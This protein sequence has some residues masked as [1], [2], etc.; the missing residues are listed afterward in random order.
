M[1]WA[2]A[3]FIVAAAGLSIFFF[4]SDL[5][6][7]PQGDLAQVHELDGQL[8]RVA[9]DRLVPLAVGDW[10][11]GKEE[12]RSGKNTHAVLRLD[13]DSLVELDERSS[14]RVRRGLRG[15]RVRVDRGRIIVE[16]SK[17]GSGH[18]RVHTD[19][20]Q[21]AV[22]GTIFGVSHGTKGSRVSVVEGEV[23]VRHAG[24]L[25]SLLGGQQLASR[26][27]LTGREIQ[28]DI[29]WSQDADRYIAMLKEMNE[30][31]KEINQILSSETRYSTRLLDLA[32]ADAAVYVALPN[33]TAKI[34]DA[35]DMIRERVSQDENFA[36][37]WSEFE[38]SEESA[39]ID[40]VMQR[41]RDLSEDLGDE[42]VFS[43]SL[44][45][46]DFAENSVDSGREP[47]PLVLSEVLDANGLRATLETQIEEIRAEIAEH[48]EPGEIHDFDV[49]IID[50]VGQ[51][52]DGK[53]NI[54]ITDDLMVISTSSAALQQIDQINSGAATNPFV[55][56]NFYTRLADAYREGT[57]FLAAVDL[58]ELVPK[59]MAAD[60][61]AAPAMM[62]LGLHNAQHLLLERRA[63]G[64]RAETAAEIQ[65]NGDRQGVMSWLAEPGPLGSLQFFSA[66]STLVTASVIR[67]PAELYREI[68]G[69]LRLGGNDPD[70]AAQTF[71]DHTGLDLENDVLATIGGE[72]AMGVD[73]PALPVPS[74]KVVVEVYDEF[75]LQSSLETLVTRANE[76]AEAEGVTIDAQLTE[77]SVNGRTFYT[78][79]ASS[80]EAA[81]DEDFSIGLPGMMESHY[82]YYDGYMIMAPS[83]A[84]IERAISFYESGANLPSSQAFRELLPEDGY[85]DF[86][87]VGYNRLGELLGDF[88]EKLPNVQSLTAEQQQEIDALR[89]ESGPSLYCL[90]GERDRIRFVSHGSGTL[91]LAGLSQLGNLQPM[92]QNI[93]SA[94]PMAQVL[95]GGG[96]GDTEEDAAREG[97]TWR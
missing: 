43:M 52:I 26:S 46:V 67:D 62:A 77:T 16:A 71:Y 37:A 22:K 38:N 42:T 68:M 30:L 70:E 76:R 13:D 61:Q 87:A 7:M 80:D 75:T 93:G 91:P 27:T 3:V 79:S 73:G 35:Y 96:F 1:R 74:W 36:E 54:W 15:D 92:V 58:G 45:G 8:F 11:D 20:I 85:I 55:G 53:L 49:M 57:Q 18:L 90:Y 19:E 10:V 69:M 60:Q 41:L 59:A 24:A 56:S 95:R 97:I 40:R 65:F 82:T 81:S 88:M 14:M 6:P 48:T 21:V 89:S 12:V 84:L 47:V 72:F 33:A 32:P 83:R 31:Q 94:T 2:A 66:D 9:D 34:A 39:Q 51:A 17:Q 23:E 78:L 5:V 50:S 28:D 29:A 44:E 86:S 64:E 63:V 4:A 25:H